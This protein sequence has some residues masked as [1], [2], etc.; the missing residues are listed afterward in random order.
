MNVTF[1]S[2]GSAIIASVEGRLDSV[3]SPSVEAQLTSRI[4]SGGLVLDFTGLDYISSAGL[5]VVLSLAKRLKQAN[6]AFILAG[7]RP[8]IR[9]VFEISGFLRI[10]DIA[11]TR[12]DALTRL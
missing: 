8:Q 7:L 6:T 3:T 10:L 1:E 4:A 11:E 9:D 2:A 5:R 12:A